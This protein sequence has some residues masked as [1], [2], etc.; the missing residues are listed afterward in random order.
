LADCLAH[1]R[2]V[3]ER[4]FRKLGYYSAGIQ[5]FFQVSIKRGL[6]KPCG[7]VHRVGAVHYGHIEAVV[8]R[9]DVFKSVH[10]PDIGAWVFQFDT[11]G[12]QV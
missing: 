5:Y 10:T 6:K 4:G 8:R 1:H 2:G 7:E 11:G 3:G 9:S 12:R